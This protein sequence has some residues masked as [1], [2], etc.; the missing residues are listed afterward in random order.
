MPGGYS[1][2]EHPFDDKRKLYPE[3][4]KASPLGI[5][6]AL[7]HITSDGVTKR[8]V[9]ESLPTCDYVNTVFGSGSLIPE[10]PYERAMVQ[11]WSSHC[12]NAIHF[13]HEVAL[14][15]KNPWKRMGHL[16]RFYSSCRLLADA[17]ATKGPFFLGSRFSMLDVILAPIW[18][19]VLWIGGHYM[20]VR[21]PKHMTR[22]FNRLQMWWEATSKRP[23]VACTMVCQDRLIAFHSDYAYSYKGPIP[24]SSMPTT[25]KK[26]TEEERSTNTGALTIMVTNN[27]IVRDNVSQEETLEYLS[28]RT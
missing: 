1:K 24:D 10:D 2:R 22:H 9:W 15:T 11:I 4:C 19:R 27:N 21:F 20:Q 16:G 12:I 5:V 28:D 14:N 6:P 18:Q 13:S 3:F 25:A 7:S 26:G 17:M 8:G 23:S